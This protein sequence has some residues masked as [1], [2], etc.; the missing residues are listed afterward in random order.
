MRHIILALCLCGATA[1]AAAPI[2]IEVSGNTTAAK[3]LDVP[4]FYEKDG[5]YYAVGEAV[6]VVATR[7][8][9]EKLALKDAVDRALKALEKKNAGKKRKIEKGAENAAL[10]ETQLNELKLGKATI[11]SVYQERWQAPDG[12]DAWDVKVKISIRRR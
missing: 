9:A 3:S 5:E 7:D 2:K 11:E 8:K 12:K 4:G 6:H 1:L 10:L